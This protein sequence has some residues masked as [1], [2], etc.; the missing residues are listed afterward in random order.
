LSV[1]NVANMSSEEALD[2]IAAHQESG[3]RL[4]AALYRRQDG[5]LIT[6]DCPV[7]RARIRAR[8]VGVV[9][10]VAAGVLLAGSV[11]M[12]F[13]AKAGGA[14]Q[15]RA[16]TLQ[17]FTKGSDWLSE[18]AARFGA[19]PGQTCVIMGDI[20]LPQQPQNVPQSSTIHWRDELGFGP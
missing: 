7:G 1:F 16:R 4:C 12:A 8:L 20:A 3:D 17:P 2:L 5:T 9:S 11:G 15:P 13:A 14:W 10:R 18:Q 19:A 6:R